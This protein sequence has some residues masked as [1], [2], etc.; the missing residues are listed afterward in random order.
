M[1]IRS[2][3]FTLAEI[4]VALVLL[5]IG[6]LSLLSVIIYSLKAG[7]FNREHHTMVVLS[8]TQMS[9]VRSQLR[10]HFD[11][12]VATNNP[13]TFSEEPDYSYEVRTSDA[14]PDRKRVELTIHY[15]GGAESQSLETWTYVYRP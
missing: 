13:T 10:I 8:E 12:P 3:G 9:R 5:S 15:Q 2:R 11:A 14:S 6:L 7:Q 4:M 1:L